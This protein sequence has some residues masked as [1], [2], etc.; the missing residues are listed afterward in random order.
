M[1][2]LQYTNSHFFTSD[3]VDAIALVID[4]E[5]RRIVKYKHFTL[6]KEDVLSVEEPS[7]VD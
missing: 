5:K 1:K 3:A 7:R 4:N 2:K 6:K